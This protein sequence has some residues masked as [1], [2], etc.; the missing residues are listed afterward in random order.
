MD[1]PTKSATFK[2]DACGHWYVTLTAEFE[3]P[4]TPL[5]PV[6]EDQVIGFDAGLKDFAVFSD[7]ERVAPPKFYRKAAKKLRKAQ[8]VL[9]RREK[10]SN[11]RTKAKKRVARVHRKI[12]NQRGDFLHKLSTRIVGANDGVGIENL[13]LK[14]MAKTKLAKSV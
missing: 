7:G 9:S 6:K 3:M 1:Y 11:N 8:R 10:G 13:N 12:A 5:E 4:D 2:R 14:G